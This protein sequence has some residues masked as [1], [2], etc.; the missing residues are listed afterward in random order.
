[1]ERVDIFHVIAQRL[2][3]G[4]GIAGLA[5]ILSLGLANRV[6]AT[7]LHSD[8]AGDYLDKGW[9]YLLDYGQYYYLDKGQYNL[10]GELGI[11]GQQAPISDYAAWSYH[12]KAGDYIDRLRYYYLDKGQY[13]Y[14]NR[15]QYNLL[16]GLGYTLGR[17]YYLRQ[18]DWGYQPV[19]ISATPEPSTILYLG[20]GAFGVLALKR[21]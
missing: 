6:Q 3:R 4:I 13:Y 2:I 7:Y 15:E 21:Y 16:G 12:F 18:Y 9:Y 11:D 14:L 1:M 19:S 10:R 5:A 8:G 17:P 20:L